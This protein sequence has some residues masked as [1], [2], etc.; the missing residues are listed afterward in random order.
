MLVIMDSVARF[1]YG[2]LDEL[3]LRRDELKPN[4]ITLSGC[5]QVRS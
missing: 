5:R 2:L 4:S 3:Q 1:L